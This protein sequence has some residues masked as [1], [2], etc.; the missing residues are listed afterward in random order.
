MFFSVVI[1]THNRLSLL[2]DSVETV[3]RQTHGD[4][5]LIVFVSTAIIMLVAV[6]QL[7]RSRMANLY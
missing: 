6:H 7:L 2:K 4:W 1:P 5:E 3:R